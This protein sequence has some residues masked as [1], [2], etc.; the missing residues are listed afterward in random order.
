MLNNL[1]GRMDKISEKL[2]KEIVRI[3]KDID[4]I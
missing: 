2:N 1:R 4:A 3:K